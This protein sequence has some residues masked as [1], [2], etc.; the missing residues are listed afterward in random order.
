MTPYPRLL[1]AVFLI[2]SCRIDVGRTQGVAGA[3]SRAGDAVTLFQNVRVFDGK[4]GSLSPPSHVLVRG[5]TIEKISTSPIPTDRRADTVLIDGG[6][7]T[8]MPGLIDMHWHTM[9]VRPTPAA[10]M[11]DDIGF[12]TLV[13]GAEATDTLMRGFTTVRDLGGP[14][15]GLKR[16]IDE[17]VVVGPADLSEWRDHDGYQWPRRFSPAVRFAAQ[18]RQCADADGAAWGKRRCR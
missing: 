5:N 8:L 2:A 17:G 13:A 3:D 4:T 16:A 15:F 18:D 7:R 1:V 14:A 12:T 6:G 9:L 11:V 10:A